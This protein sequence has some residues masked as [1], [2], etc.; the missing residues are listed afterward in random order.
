MS[1]EGSS[2]SRWRGR[3]LVLLAAVLWSLSGAFT[4][5][6]TGS[7]GL[8]AT[9]GL[10]DPP[11]APLLIAFFRTFFA[12][13]FF[14][15]WLGAVRIRFRL[16]MLFMVLSFTAMNATFVSAMVIGTAANAIVLQYTA[17]LWLYLAGIWWLKESPD[18]RSTTALILA[19]TGV[20]IIVVDACIY[21]TSDIL[22]GILLGLASGLAYAGVVFF[23][24]VLR[25]E[26]GQWLTVQNHLCAALFLS[27]LLFWLPW[28]TWSQIGFLA[29]YGVVQM[30]IPYMLLSRGLR[31]VSASEAGTLTLLE[32]ILNPL[33]TYLAVGEVPATA[34]FLGGA[35]IL[36]G[37]AWR[38]LPAFRQ[39]LRSSGADSAAA[40]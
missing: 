32:P 29:I 1:R 10:N 5:I 21:A 27:P 9:L 36:C 3:L 34:T 20:A 14:L 8:A 38:Y 30:G 15:P 11:P 6:L 33:W 28:P 23:L 25:D 40:N 19:M 7:E 4:K 35:M 24:R 13:L 31:T 26:P 18:R 22:W 37:L 2:A 12:A 17:P 16:P 39:S